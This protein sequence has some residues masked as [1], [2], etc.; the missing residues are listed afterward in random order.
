MDSL[1]P[2]LGAAQ[3]LCPPEANHRDPYTTSHV[4]DEVLTLRLL[5]V[6][7]VKTIITMII[8]MMI[9]IEVIK[10]WASFEHPTS[11]LNDCQVRA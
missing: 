3:V 4:I 9:L 2:F 8:T 7:F 10:V 5:I 6:L 1:A 11:R